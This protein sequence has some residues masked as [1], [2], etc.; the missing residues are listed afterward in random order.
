MFSP[1][2]ANESDTLECET[3]SSTEFDLGRVTCDPRKTAVAV[4]MLQWNAVSENDHESGMV[5]NLKVLA[6]NFHFIELAVLK[7]N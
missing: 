2:V 3:V 4:L 6:W 5:P 7:L 1:V